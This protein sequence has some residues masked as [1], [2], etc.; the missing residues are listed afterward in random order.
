MIKTKVTETLKIK[1]PIFC[2][3]MMNI[4][5]PE[6]AAAC[7]N[8][9]ALG[10]MASVMYRT[11]DPLREAIQKLKSLTN[12]PFAVNVNLFPMIMPVKQIDLVKVMIDEGVKII[13]TSGHKA[14]EKYVPLFKDN[15]VTWIHKCAGI[16]YAQKAA[17][18]GADMV[19]VVGWENGG[20][21]GRFDIGTLVLTPATI[22]A[23][24]I[25]VIAG[26]GISDGRGLAAVLALGAE[27][28]L[29]GTRIM[30]TKECP[31]HENLKQ[32]LL[33]A[34]IYDTA[35]VMRSIDATHRVWNN[36]AA[37]KIIELE[38]QK[39]DPQLIFGEAAGVKSKQM[40]DE[41]KLDIGIVSCGQGVGLIHDIPTVKDLV[42][43]IMNQAEEMLKKYPN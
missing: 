28:G 1:Y 9:G 24:E 29:M 43:R 7:S 35:L 42:E 13:E 11:Q 26:G 36:A 17:S 16:R 22:D 20:A 23:L 39:A 31:I 27:A 2:G 41:G 21:T 12:K 32:A 38:N 18:L 6:F 33:K 8:S 14:P 40:Y 15:D 37:Q 5:I 34:S 25:P 30:A 3:N 10:I 19:E 4:S